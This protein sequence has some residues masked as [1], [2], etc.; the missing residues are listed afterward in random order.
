MIRNAYI[1]QT[2][3]EYRL[4]DIKPTQAYLIFDAVRRVYPRRLKPL[5]VEG[6]CAAW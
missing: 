5:N 3:H 2:R 4:Q 1:N 6:I